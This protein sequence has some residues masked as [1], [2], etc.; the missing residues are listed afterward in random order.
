MSVGRESGAVSIICAVRS[1]SRLARAASAAACKL[2]RRLGYRSQ[3]YI[4]RSTSPLEAVAAGYV[5][6]L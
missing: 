5:K 4:Q 2:E 1:A 6:G 3:R